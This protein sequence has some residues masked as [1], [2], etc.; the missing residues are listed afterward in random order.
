[1]EE[2]DDLYYDDWPDPPEQSAL[3]WFG[4]IDEELAVSILQRQWHKDKARIVY[5]H[6]QHYV[7]QRHSPGAGPWYLARFWSLRLA[8]I[9]LQWKW[10]WVQRHLLRADLKWHR[11][12]Y[13][14]LY[15][16]A[17]IEAGRA[18][19]MDED[20]FLTGEKD[21]TAPPVEQ[22]TKTRASKIRKLVRKALSIKFPWDLESA[23]Y[24][25][26]RYGKYG[27]R[28]GPI[29]RLYRKIQEKEPPAERPPP[30]AGLEDGELLMEYSLPPFEEDPVP[31]LYPQV[32]T[33]AIAVNLCSVE[34]EMA[35]LI[36][37][38]PMEV[39]WHDKPEALKEL[40]ERVASKDLF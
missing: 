36:R 19:L 34:Q 12:K 8:F 10:L 39:D 2:P 7:Q 3:H 21:I 18:D 38:D 16:D 35:E 6:A 29:G 15:L 27:M 22:M 14:N 40:N 37:K 13:I 5:A 31:Q 30:I 24:H 33:V 28:F 4:K 1:M 17:C 9:P 32:L 26:L 11:Q 20:G 25:G 23:Y